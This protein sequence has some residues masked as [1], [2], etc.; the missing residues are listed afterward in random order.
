MVLAGEATWL[1]YV[2]QDFL[3]IALN[4]FTKVYGPISCLAAWVALVALEL[5]SPVLPIATLDRHCTAHDMDN[6]VQCVSGVL[7]IGNLARFVEIFA[8]MGAAMLAALVLGHV[9]VLMCFRRRDDE[10]PTRHLLGVADLYVASEAGQAERWTLDKVSC[11][12]A[13]L[14]SLAWGRHSFTFDIKLWVLREDND[15]ATTTTKV[16]VHHARRRSSLQAQDTLAS[17]TAPTNGSGASSKQTTSI[18]PLWLHHALQIAAS[19]WRMFMKIRK[20]VMP[21]FGVMHAVGSIVGSVSYL[22]VSQVNLANDLFWANFNTTGTHAFIATWLNKQLLL[23]IHDGTT[24]KLTTTSINVDGPFAV[25][26]AIL[27][28][29]A[30]YGAMLQFSELNGVD[31]T[32]RGLR[33]SDGCTA[34]WIFTQYCYVDFQQQW[35]LA[36]SAA[37]QRRC[38][39]MTAN[40]AV[41]LESILRN[42]P[43]SDFYSCWGPAYESAIAHDLRQST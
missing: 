2:S 15:S 25:S 10:I 27:T 17:A 29:A 1:L 11:L 32:I 35:Q 13:G 24:T 33:L 38:Q 19:L 9:G 18:L 20:R 16:F 30:N 42:I 6:S 12:M 26:P 23:G 37:R 21:A 4:R 14:V 39:A 36:N 22:Q 40:G 3:T 41:F 43:F 34:P 28:P 8:V 7:Q 5:A 31:E